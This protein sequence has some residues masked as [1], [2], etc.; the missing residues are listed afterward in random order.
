MPILK[1]AHLQTMG[2]VSAKNPIELGG[3]DLPQTKTYKLPDGALGNIATVNFLIQLAR[4]R[5]TH[6][7]IRQLAIN[8]LKQASTISMHY[9]D[10]AVA[11]AKWVRDNVPYLK[12]ISNVETVHD[13]I[14]M[15]DK[16][17]RGTLAVDCDDQA[18]F[19]ATLL[20]SIGHKP[21][22]RIVKYNHGYPSYNHIYVYE[23]TK[24]RGG[25]DKRLVMDAIM[26]TKQIG[27]EVPHVEGK[28]F[29]I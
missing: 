21:V 4:K 28:D 17:K 18:L 11:I 12:D 22:F 19:I 6:P 2:G 3:K 26:K 29:L 8:I 5:S 10:E 15:I 23:V 24:N 7:L 9:F 14:T 20:L 1:L 25:I 16:Y 13:P 27:Y